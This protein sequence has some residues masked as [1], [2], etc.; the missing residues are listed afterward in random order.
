MNEIGTIYTQDAGA[1]Q[2]CCQ[3]HKK[4]SKLLTHDSLKK[5]DVNQNNESST[6]LDDITE[7]NDEQF[8]VV[9]MPFD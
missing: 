6:Q 2:N 9:D 1:I 7:T 8:Q 3:Y 5:N 4:T